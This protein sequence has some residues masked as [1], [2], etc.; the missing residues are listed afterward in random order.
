MQSRRALN[1]QR[2]LNAAANE[3]A[4]SGAYGPSLATIA[5]KANLSRQYAYLR[6]GDREKLYQA[7]CEDAEARLVTELS[8][9]DFQN[10]EPVDCLEQFFRTLLRFH[11][12]TPVLGAMLADN[13]ILRIL[14]PKYISLRWSTKIRRLSKDSRPH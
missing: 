6:F 7:V 5:A 1:M 9:L 2:L 10:G 8:R 14:L 13:A 11:I 3:F 4:T 12:C